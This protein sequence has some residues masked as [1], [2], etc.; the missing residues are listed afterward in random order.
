MGGKLAGSKTKWTH[1]A[2]M[3]STRAHTQATSG[4]KTVGN[5]NASRF[6]GKAHSVF[7]PSPPCRRSR[8]TLPSRHPASFQG[9]SFVFGSFLGFLD[10]NPMIGKPSFHSRLVQRAEQA[11]GS[12]ATPTEI[13]KHVISRECPFYRKDVGEK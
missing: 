5:I 9:F 6:R 10:R 1:R 7:L 2:C 11:I 8:S 12:I 13:V 4:Y 3:H